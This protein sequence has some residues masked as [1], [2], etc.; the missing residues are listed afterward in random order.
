M[1]KEIIK[2][3]TELL[4]LLSSPF[5]DETYKRQATKI[6][7]EIARLEREFVGDLTHYEKLRTQIFLKQFQ[8]SEEESSDFKV[9][10]IVNIKNID[11]IYHQ[12][13]HIWG[14]HG[15]GVYREIFETKSSLL[16]AFVNNHGVKGLKQFN[17]KIL[18]IGEYISRNEKIALV[19]STNTLHL[20]VSLNGLEKVK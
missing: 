19:E 11:E 4:G 6:G 1:L 14:Q 2:L 9:G 3:Q 16:K 13:S 10:D 15:F 5:Y 7:K 8:E 20:L 18:A 12:M 17:Y